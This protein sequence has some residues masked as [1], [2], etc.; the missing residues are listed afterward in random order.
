M[1]SIFLCEINE[2]IAK[3]NEELLEKRNKINISDEELEK[4]YDS[5]KVIIEIEIRF[6]V[7]RNLLIN[8]KVKRIKEEFINW[9][10]IIDYLKIRLCLDAI[11]QFDRVKRSPKKYVV[12]KEEIIYIVLVYSSEYIGIYKIETNDIDFFEL[13]HLKK[14]EEEYK[15]I[16]EFLHKR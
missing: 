11:K 8:E 6:I 5:I 13:Y 10:E 15:Y 2:A 4:L 9:E 7:R 12:F 16:T 14:S 1:D 3:V